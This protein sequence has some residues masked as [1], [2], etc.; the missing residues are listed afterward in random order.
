MYTKTK[1][2]AVSVLLGK[3]FAIVFLAIFLSFTSSFAQTVTAPSHERTKSEQAA[4]DALAKDID[5]ATKSK[6]ADNALWGITIQS[7]KTGEV[8]YETNAKKSFLPASNM[9]LVTSALALTSLTPTFQY[10]TELFTNGKFNKK[11]MTGDL[12]IRGAGD[13]TFGSTAMF[14]D[15]EPSSV[16]KQWVDTLLKRGIEKIEG[17][18]IVDDTYFTEDIYPL[19][20]AIDDAPFYYA[21]QTSALSFADNVVSV[22]VAPNAQP[23]SR[24]FVA[25]IP[26]TDYVEKENTAVT[27]PTDDTS[28]T[29]L[30]ITR[31]MGGNEIAVSGE[32]PK[33]SNAIFEQ[34]TVES[35]SLYAGTVYKEEL[36]F[37]GITVTGGVLTSRELKEK[38]QYNSLSHLGNIQSPPLPEIIKVMNKRSNNFFAEQLFRTIAKESGGK[39]DWKTGAD[40]AKKYLALIGIADDRFAIADGSGLSRM[41]MVTPEGIVAILRAMQR[42][43]KLYPPFLESLPIMGKDGTLSDRL[44]GTPAEGKVFAKT[45]G[46]TGVRSL[47]GYC[48]D[49]DGEQLAFCIITNNFTSSMREITA[50]Q[51]SIAL[52]L[53][54]FSRK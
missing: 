34:I 35:P 18:I 21:T 26:E 54:N 53:V 1:K 9:K 22:S 12:I 28:F 7:L 15:K 48:T 32:I 13:P 31:V 29:P 50:L 20:W 10:S 41:D 11:V 2:N 14:P 27:I 43:A 24:P 8:L 51:D 37:A 17:N 6:Y 38:L 33:G 30:T 16:F 45:G 42:D 23:G 47:A 46:L 39:G 4:I 44:K 49:A 19:G 25:I 3:R 40:A 36:Q 52:R 5:A